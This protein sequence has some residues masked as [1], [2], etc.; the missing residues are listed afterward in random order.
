M[1]R[2]SVVTGGGTGIGRAV[3]AE[4]ARN[5]DQVV[6]AGRRTEMLA[7][8]AK[9]I[10]GD[11]RPITADLSDP[12]DVARVRD[13]VADDFGRVDVLVNNAGGNT[14]LSDP[15]GDGL[16]DL[17]RQWT[18]NFQ[19]NVL[20]AVLTTEALSGLLA[21][22]G[23][24]V[25]VSSI[26]AMRGSGAG[27]YGSVKAALHP[28]AY[29]LATALGPRGITVNVVAPGFTEETEF[30]GGGMTEG[31]R[32]ALIGQTANRRPGRPAD[33]AATVAWLAS[34]GAGHVTAQIIQVNGGAE[35]GR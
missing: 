19:A 27:S 32:A 5:G 1:A 21:G 31:R 26:A 2:V 7:Q 24:V 15:G 29:N 6:I 9:S 13:V 30:F 14:D 25:L 28:Y 34:P 4:L 23:R 35:R 33:V 20:T 10:D 16:P 22:D 12:G 11:V 18:R 3:A 8:A 17:A